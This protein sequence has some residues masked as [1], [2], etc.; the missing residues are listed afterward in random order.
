MQSLQDLQE[1]LFF[2]CKNIL[3]SVSK[4]TTQ[5]ELLVKHDLLIELTDRINILKYLEKNKDFFSQNEVV[6]AQSGIAELSVSEMEHDDLM[7][8]IASSEVEEEVLFTNELNEIHH[9]E[10]EM[11]PQIEEEEH[12]DIIA[13]QQ[14]INDDEIYSAPVLE[15]VEEINYNS[16][17]VDNQYVEAIVL[18]DESK[19]IQF[20]DKIDEPIIEEPITAAAQEDSIIEED[21][22]AVVVNFEVEEK[23]VNDAPIIDEKVIEEESPIEHETLQQAQEKKFKLANIKGVKSVQSLFDDD[24]FEPM[25]QEKPA[26]SA[27]DVAVKAKVATVHKEVEKPKSEF[28][29]DLNDKI[30][31]SKTLFAGSQTDMNDAIRILNSCDN[32]EQ[33]KEFLSDLYYER[34]WKKA[35]DYAQRLWTLVENK[36]N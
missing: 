31:F 13:N 36:F 29:L 21:S 16:L 23:I 5:E 14:D 32:I 10:E 27:V 11:E 28:K 6:E 17:D 19:E 4:I 24:M 33:A 12:I 25:R 20:E 34:N 8:E 15:E 2:E 18:E 9:E 35:D 1:K 22:K 30:A 7:E 3:E 26:V